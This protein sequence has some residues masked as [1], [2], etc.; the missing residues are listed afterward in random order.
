MAKNAAKPIKVVTKPTKPA[1]SVCPC[2]CGCGG[3]K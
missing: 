1:A 2:P 3:A